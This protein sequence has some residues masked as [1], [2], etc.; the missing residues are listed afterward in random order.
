MADAAWMRKNR[1]FTRG[2][3]RG[4]FIIRFLFTESG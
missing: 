3:T 4:R 2:E 1:K